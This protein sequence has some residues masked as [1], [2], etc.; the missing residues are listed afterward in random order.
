M[1]K[2]ECQIQVLRSGV[3]EN[4]SSN[5]LV[6]GDVVSVPSNTIMPCDMVLTKGQCVVNESMLTGE[7]VPVIKNAISNIDDKFNPNSDN[8]KKHVLYGGTK[9]IQARKLQDA[10]IQALVIRI[11]FMTNKGAL[12]RSILF[13]RETKFKFYRDSLYFVGAMALIGITGFCF[14][15][16]KLIELGTTTEKLIDKSLDL[17]TV[18]VP[19]ALPATMTVGV[20]FAISRL[21]K[22]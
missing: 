5:E 4:I 8:S 11:G 15:I 18:T 9:V 2:Y 22:S 10:C 16:P 1:A 14:T 17:I 6:P 3:L 13:P 20:A 7:S 21:K 19:P 12:V